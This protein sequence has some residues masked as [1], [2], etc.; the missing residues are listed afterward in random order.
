MRR[1]PR[2]IFQEEHEMRIQ[3]LIALMGVLA[4][5][6]CDGTPGKD[7]ADGEPGADGAAGEPGADGAA[8][9]DGA[10]GADGADATE[11]DADGDGVAALDDCDDDDAAVGGPTEHYIDYDGDGYGYPGVINMLCEPMTGWVDNADDCDDLDATLSPAATE[12]CDEIDNDCDGA[13]DDEDDSLDAVD[14]IEIYAD[15]DGDG[16]GDQSAGATLACT[17]LSGYSLIEGDCDDGDDAINPEAVEICDNGIDENCDGGAPECVF[18]SDTFVV[19]TDADHT[20]APATSSYDYFGKDFAIADIN[21]DGYDDLLGAAYGDDTVG[22]SAGAV[23]VYYGGSSLGS[24]LSTP[25]ATVYGTGSS[26]YFGDGIQAAGDVNGDGYD[27]VIVSEN[28]NDTAYLMYGSTS[29][30][31]GSYTVGTLVSLSGGATITSASPYTFGNDVQGAGDVDGDGYDDVLVSDYESSSG[32]GTAYLLLGSASGL[33]GSVVADTTAVASF[34][35]STT[36]GYLGF[37]ES[38]AMGDFNG[39]GYGDI[40]AGEYGNDED[41]SNYGRAYLW[42]GPSTGALDASAAAVTFTAATS[43]GDSYLG[44]HSEYLGDFNGDGLDDLAIGAQYYDGA[45]Y[46]GGAVFVYY[47]ATS[48]ASTVDT[49]DA[50]LEIRGTDSSLSIS[51]PHMLGDLD[52]DGRA[53]LMV[54]GRYYEPASSGLYSTGMGGVFMGGT[55]SGVYDAA[56]DGIATFKASSSYM[57]L[58]YAAEGGDIDGDG[59]SEVYVGA[60]GANSS[61]GAIYGFELGTGAY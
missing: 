19:E 37:E 5:A 8:G 38:T 36:S 20:L 10:P 43:T 13:I 7:G 6:A 9:A 55:A 1:V 12:V 16:Y 35:G 45:A 3:S 42:T 29:T 25:S 33:S 30:L 28:G 60:Y 46:D 52:G 39:D 26:D 11:T 58:G 48:W 32:T 41:G 17:L 4:I 21:G 57:Y 40:L 50:D 18:T 59:T 47:G 15:T 61:Q 27:D 24:A 2:Q 22:S 31:S 34:S 14:G 53:D 54:G 49:V 23:Y 44:Y 56:T 51:A